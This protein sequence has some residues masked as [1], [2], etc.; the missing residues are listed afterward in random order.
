MNKILSICIVSLLICESF[1]LSLGREQSSGT[2][3]ILTCNGKPLAGVRVKLFDDDRGI[4]SDDLLDDS[5]TNEKGEFNLSGSTS[6]IT[7]IDPK[8]NIYHDCEDGIRPC[9]R[10]M[11]IFIPDSYVSSGPHPKKIYDA[12]TIEL[13]GKFPGEERDCLH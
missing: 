6:E 13:S 1:G 12:G 2:K 7:T 8:I 10:K 11:T 4:D 9:Q 5:K 3:G